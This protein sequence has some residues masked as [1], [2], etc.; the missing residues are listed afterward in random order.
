MSRPAIAVAL[1][2]DEYAPVSAELTE[3][4]L[5]VVEIRRPVDLEAA[6]SSRR[7]IALAIIDG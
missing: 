2:P 5:A 4:G 1:P 3:A 7:D 6:L